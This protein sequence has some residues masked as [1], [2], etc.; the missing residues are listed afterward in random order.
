MASAMTEGE[1]VS[2]YYHDFMAAF[3]VLDSH[4][5][6]ALRQ[7]LEAVELALGILRTSVEDLTA[8]V[9]AFF[10]CKKVRGMALTSKRQRLDALELKVHAR[11]FGACS[12]AFALKDAGI[13]ANK[14]VPLP[15]YD[16]RVKARLGALGSQ[17]LIFDLRNGAHGRILP[18]AWQ[19][20]TDTAPESPVR[21]RFLLERKALERV[22]LGPLSREYINNHPDGIDVLD[23]FGGYLEEVDEV[24][25][26]FGRE[27]A[28]SA[29][30]EFDEHVRL[31]KRLRSEELW[32]FWRIILEQVLKDADPY[33]YLPTY[34]SEDELREVN[35]LPQRSAEQV[36]AI[37]RLLD[38][39]DCCDARLR[40]LAYRKFDVPSVAPSDDEESR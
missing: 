40:K 19:I 3:G 36:D 32:A 33:P 9:G 29:G 14:A 39:H 2:L 23:L 10:Q 17:S 15:E 18:P 31:E 20:S 27:F 13:V 12:A 16:A 30:P 22:R 5:G 8:A 7:R 34:L 24:Y 21:E 1:L 28:R 26:W 35:G 6:N 4:K 25:D 37:I 38:P 11:V